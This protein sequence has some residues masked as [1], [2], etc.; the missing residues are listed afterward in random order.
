MQS[1]G[2]PATTDWLGLAGK[3]VLLVGAGGFGC[4]LTRAYLDAGAKVFVAD[5]DP[6]RLRALADEHRGRALTTAV[7]DVTSRSQCDELV[8]RAADAQGIDVFVHAAGVNVRKPV[9]ELSDEEWEH[10]QAVNLRSGF[11]LGQRVGEW[12]RAHGGG[13]MVYF[14]SVSG[15]LAHPHHAAYAASKGALNQLLKVMAVEWAADG[16][17]VNAVAPGYAATPL[18]AAYT[19]RPGMM[20][21]L[22]ERVPMGRI[23]TP[24]DV[25]GPT[26]FLSSPRSAYVTGQVLYVD[27]GRV[28]D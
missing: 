11:W 8:R 1:P 5:V 10:I 18:T 12:M 17:A 16:I 21:K 14:S 15:L 27:G 3:A 24:E 23:G 20:S 9:D 19:A 25:V 28:L 26:L 7:C 13:R 2:T 6:E 4:A 22:V